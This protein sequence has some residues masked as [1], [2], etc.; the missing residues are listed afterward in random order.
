MVLGVV[1]V[2]ASLAGVVS[3]VAGRRARTRALHDALWSRGCAGLRWHRAFRSAPPREVRAFLHL[4]ARAFDFAP[5]RAL[6]LDP[7]DSIAELLRLSA[8]GSLT[9]VLDAE[10]LE[11]IVD[12]EYSVRLTLAP[13]ATLGDL[14]TA[15]PGA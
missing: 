14:F 7:E 1:F 15:T 11:E 2:V 5:R 3:I 10:L 13:D 12:D 8:I 4:V 6:H 9:D